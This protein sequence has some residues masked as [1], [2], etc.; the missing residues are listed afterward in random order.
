M[1]KIWPVIFISL[2]LLI[3]S[4]YAEEVVYYYENDPYA[5]ESD[6]DSIVE[7]YYDEDNESQRAEAFAPQYHHT[8]TKRAESVPEKDWSDLSEFS[9][10][11][12][13]QIQ[14][15]EKV[16]VVNPRRH[17]WGAYSKEGVLLH[18]GLATSG[19]TWC[20]DL[21]RSCRTKVGTFRINSLGASN[22]KSSR[23]PLH[24]GGAPMP[25]CMYFNG[26]QGIHGS[27]EV[28]E[29]NRSHGCVRVRVK[30][31]EWLRFHFATI[32]TKV[33]IMNY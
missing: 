2:V 12:S 5:Q 28:S 33:I 22:C 29:G 19:S 11:L 20:A 4:S 31:A 32:G 30:D 26:N 3:R 21:G 24:K 14:P 1:R 16:I 15:G 7:Y 18:A 27:Y 10:R 8:R 17:V 25:Y 23:Y 6:N 13:H 9:S